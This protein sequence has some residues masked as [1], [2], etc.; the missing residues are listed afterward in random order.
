MPEPTAV[1]C[2]ATAGVGRAS[3]EAF[4]RA[5][6]RV[7]LIARGEQGLSDTQAQLEALGARVLA[8]AADVADAPAL[9]AAATRV[10]AE[11]GPI[12]VWVNAAM[13]TVFG[14][15]SALTPEEIRRVTEVTYL[16][17]VHGTLTALRH[18]RPRNRGTIVQVGS[19][20]AYRA[21]PLQSAYCGAKFA[22]RG[23]IDSLRCELI[24]DKSAIRL[25]M[26]QLPAHN[27][28]Q[29]DWARNR[30]SRRAQPVP[31][32]HTPDVAARAILRAARNAPR[33]LW[34]GAAS[35]KA[36][37][38]TQLMP[39]LLDRMLAR[40]AWDGQLTAE[41]APSERPDNLFEPV[42]GLHRTDG[43][44][45]EQAVPR[46]VSLS[47]ATASGLAVGA[48]ALLALGVGLLLGRRRR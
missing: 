30:M 41:P 22:I 38:G 31:P 45:T 12:D 13:A 23:F 37:L 17:S 7:A 19:A 33:E 35:F 1:I 47:A 8:I 24:H 5:G 36:I 34:L 9:E 46:A 25:T 15:F 14:P 32:I 40:Q 44:F 2:G 4:A 48:G 21:I 26:V 10:E 39:G 43:R 20:L 28:P 27:T 29:F 16:G 11:L 6:Y 42:E 3:A 18:M